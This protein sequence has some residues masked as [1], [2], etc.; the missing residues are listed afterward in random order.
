MTHGERNLSEYES[1]L[2]PMARGF[3]TR[4]QSATGGQLK[5]PGQPRYRPVPTRFSQSRESDRNPARAHL[6]AER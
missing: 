3:D 6:A 5:C 2:E 1:A 4:S